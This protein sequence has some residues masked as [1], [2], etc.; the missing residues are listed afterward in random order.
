MKYLLHINIYNFL[1]CPFIY[2]TCI[3][4][5]FFTVSKKLPNFTQTELN[6]YIN[7]SK[8]SQV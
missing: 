3:S 1:K 8:S 5:Y 4:I 7:R 6:D 2:N